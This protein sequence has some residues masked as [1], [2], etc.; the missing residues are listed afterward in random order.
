MKRHRNPKGHVLLIVD[1]Q[2]AFD[3]PSQLQD[4][5]RKYAKRFRRCIFTQFVNPRGS[6]FRTKLKQRCCANGSADLRL[7]IEPGPDDWVIEKARYGLAAN[8]IRRIK[9]ARVKRVTVCGVDTD[10]CVLGV[11]FSL[12]DAGIDCEV[13]ENLCWS[14]SG[15]HREAIRILRKQ[16]PSRR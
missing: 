8:D 7:L 6:P 15:L 5:L 10:A 12:F 14:S 1:V 2:A 3:V 16:F 4:R 9:S 11:M 13:K